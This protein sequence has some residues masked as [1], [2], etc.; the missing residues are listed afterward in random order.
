MPVGRHTGSRCVRYE[1]SSKMSL[2]SKVSLRTTWVKPVLGKFKFD[3]TCSKT[4]LGL[5]IVDT[6]SAKFDTFAV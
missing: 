4:T 5:S 1:V 6:F 3:L 2:D